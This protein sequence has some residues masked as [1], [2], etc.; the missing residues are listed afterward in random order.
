MELPAYLDRIGYTGSRTP[1]LATLRALMRAHIAAIPFENLDVQLGRR[2]GLE[3][4][5][6][7]AKLV[8]ARR[9][10]WCY[11]NNGLFGWA[12]GALGFDVRRITAGVL[13]AAHGDSAIGNHLALIVTLEQ[14]WLVDVGFGGTQ[15]APIPLATGDYAHA[16]YDLALRQIEGGYWRFEERYAGD[17]PFS[18]DFT[19]DPA[20]EALFARQCDALQSEPD[21]I[22]VENLVV[23]QRRGDRHTALRGRM[24]VAR[25][26]GGETR[27]MLAEAGDLVTTL[28]REFGLDLP[29]AAALWDKVCARHEARF[30]A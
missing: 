10:G 11:E 3:L 16:P 26:P 7:F 18:F 2:V 21:S 17:D 4:P 25:E 1:D 24:L 15:A 27:R 12:L 28:A 19:T 29:E 8:E 23:Q 6:I 5:M 20:D 22:F 14:P 13:R 30:E 9:G